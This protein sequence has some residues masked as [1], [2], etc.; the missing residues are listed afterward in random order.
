MSREEAKDILL[1]KGAKVTSTISK[2]TDFL[3]AGENAGSKI[4]KAEKNDVEGN[5]IYKNLK[6]EFLEKYMPTPNADPH[7]GIDDFRNVD[8]VVNKISTN[9]STN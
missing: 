4:E 2:N 7:G 8:N 6:E 1:S 9:W 5:R 3:I